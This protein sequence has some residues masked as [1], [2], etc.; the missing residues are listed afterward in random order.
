MSAPNASTPAAARSRRARKKAIT[1][2]EI[3]RAAMRL[4]RRRGFDGVTIEEICEEAD[5]AR[6]TFF[7]HFPTKAALLY[8]WN[9]E[10]AEEVRGRLVEPRGSAV[11]E[12]EILARVFGER[13]RADSEI[14]TALLREYYSAPHP[15]VSQERAGNRELQDLLQAIIARGQER[16]ELSSRVCAALAAETIIAVTSAI[17]SGVLPPGTSDEEARRQYFEIV[18]HGIGAR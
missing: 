18:L 14:M 1:R 13:L 12:L 11:E 4:F 3:Y 16:G 15:G 2:R 6:G 5:V 7:L 10:I 8:E 17:L 9:A